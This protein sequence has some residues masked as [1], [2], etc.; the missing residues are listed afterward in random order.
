MGCPVGYRPYGRESLRIVV[1]FAR[2]RA[3]LGALGSQ[4]EALVR[5]APGQFGD[6]PDTT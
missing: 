4:S 1:T 6:W 5:H 3:G 2:I